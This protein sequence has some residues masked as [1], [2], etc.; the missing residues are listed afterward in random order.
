MTPYNMAEKHHKKD[1]D[2][3][4]VPA[5]EPES[6]N[7]KKRIQSYERHIC[8]QY[9]SDTGTEIMVVN[10]MKYFFLHT[11]MLISERLRLKQIKST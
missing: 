3:S 11:R 2:K 6:T 10:M 1:A 4:T 7:N 8:S 9:S 5:E